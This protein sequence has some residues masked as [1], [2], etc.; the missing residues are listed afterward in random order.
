[1]NEPST[2][3]RQRVAWSA[4]EKVD[5]VRMFEK[6]GQAVSEFCRGNGL[7]ESTFALWRKQLRGPEIGGEDGAL[8]QIATTQLRSAA[9]IAPAVECAGLKVRLP[10]GVEI[11]VATGTDAQWFAG[12]VHA[13]RPVV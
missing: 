12:I 11:D 6:S 7:P 3:K 2:A 4:E 13:L 10:C 5:W 8:V 1:M 9:P